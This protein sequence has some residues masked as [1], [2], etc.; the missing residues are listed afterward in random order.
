MPYLL[1]NCATGKGFPDIDP[2]LKHFKDAFD[3]L[4]ADRTGRIFPHEGVDI[5]YDSA[6]RI[7][8]DVKCCLERHLKEQQKAFGDDSV[9]TYVKPS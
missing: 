2:V 4:E 1:T 3:W 9:S 7:V 5:E 8:N 6:C